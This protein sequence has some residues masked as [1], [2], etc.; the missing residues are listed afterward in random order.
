LG[1]DASVLT[2]RFGDDYER[3]LADDSNGPQVDAYKLLHYV[4]SGAVPFRH[5][6][7]KP[8]P[9]AQDWADVLRMVEPARR[10][11]EG[12]ESN[13]IAGARKAGLRWRQIAGA[14][15]LDS[16]QAAQ[17]RAHRLG[18]RV[19]SDDGERASPDGSA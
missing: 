17:Q 18:A 1:I 12:L 9:T 8:E 4:L 13:V 16:P 19:T 10:D 3:R 15:G 6:E 11:L 2:R 7:T 14:L 5:D